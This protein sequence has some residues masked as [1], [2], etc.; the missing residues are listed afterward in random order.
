MAVGVA[1]A[2]C[3]GGGYGSTSYE[4]SSADGAG[5]A[6]GESV[7]VPPARSAHAYTTPSG[8]TVIVPGVQQGVVIE[9]HREPPPQAGLLTAASVGDCDRRDNYLDYL[10]RHPSEMSR[11]SID[12]S[13]RMRFRVV[14]GSGRPVNAARVSVGGVSGLTH[15]DGVW[16]FFPSLSMPQGASAVPVVVESGQARVELVANVPSSG[17]APDVTVQLR[18]QTALAP[19]HLDLAFLIDVTGSMEDELRY[20]NREVADIVQRVRAAAPQTRIRVGATFYRD[21]V[22]ARPVE[23]IPFGED[24]SGFGQAMQRVFASGGG[25]YP[26][27]VDTGLEVALHR[28]EWS[29]GNAVR[30]LVWV[31]DAPPQHYADQQ[32]THRHAMAEASARGIRVLP[33]AASGADR[34]TEY[35]MRAIGAFTSTPYVYITDDSGIGGPHMDADTDRVAVETLNRLLVRLLIAD[36]N[37]EG[38]H[39]PGAF[40]PRAGQES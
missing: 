4:A 6:G 1:L 38:M 29:E 22:D 17:D 30:V 3:G 32:F 14:D 27:D 7:Y 37:G 40:G 33:V 13:R 5:Y 31:A 25:D 10:R 20:V 21:R 26:E 8:T 23:Q 35:V 36:L 11:S 9:A 15:A 34:M 24:V 2:A 16:D 12:L 19:A 39:E 28:M 18:G